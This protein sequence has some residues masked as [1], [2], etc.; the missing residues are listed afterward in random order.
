MDFWS[1]AKSAFGKYASASGRSCRSEFWY[2]FLLCVIVDTI[3][4]LLD[5]SLTRPDLIEPLKDLYGFF[6][7]PFEMIWGIFA[8]LPSIAVGIRRLHDIDLAGWW[9]LLSLIPIIGVVILIVLW[10][11]KGT[12][13]LNHFGENPLHQ[14]DQGASQWPI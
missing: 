8:F 5:V 14:A 13:G 11:R 12:A 4:R 7:G 9:L 2:F 6:G 1:A 3:A 10:S